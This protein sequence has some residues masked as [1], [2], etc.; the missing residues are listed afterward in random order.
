MAITLATGS[1]QGSNCASQVP[2]YPTTGSYVV[3]KDEPGEA[4]LTNVAGALDQP[5]SIRFGVSAI[6]D[7][8]RNTPLSPAPGQSVA[9]VSMLAQVNEVWKL[10]DAAD[11]LSPLYVPASAHL[12]VKVA[13]DA[14][15]TPTVVANLMLRLF[16][17]PFRNGTDSLA[18]A[19]T[20]WLHGVARF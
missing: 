11:S 8:F 19:I 18:T 9:G 20:S 13:S 10:D 2:L 7:I 3:S 17:A 1:A 14:L 16:G 4:I 15:V 5:N 6:S 12:V